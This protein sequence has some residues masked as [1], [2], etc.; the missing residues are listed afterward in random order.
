MGGMG[1][2]WSRAVRSSVV[3]L[4]VVAALGAGL[5]HGVRAGVSAAGASTAGVSGVTPRRAVTGDARTHDPSLAHT[6]SGW[7]V[8]STGDPAVAGGTVQI[9]FSPDGRNWAFTGTIGSSIPAWVS[10]AV[11]GVSNLWA[12]D[13]SFHNGRWYLYYAASTFGSNR[14]IIGLFT[15]PTLDPKDPRYAWTDQGEVTE[16]VTTDDFNAIDPNLFVDTTGAAW[17]AFGSFWSGV[18]LV[19]VSFP[20]GKPATVH[21]DRVSLVDRHFGPNAVEAPFLVAHG[22]WYY[23]FVSFD[24]CCQGANSTY[25]LV[26]G[27]SSTVTGPYLDRSGKSLLAGGATA[28]L[29]AQGDM[30]GPG[31]ASVSGDTV[32][33]H[34]YDAAKAGDFHLGL[35]HLGF[36]DGWPVITDLRI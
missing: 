2:G 19:P 7:Y 11:P 28:T 36:R 5:G 17:L 35:G 26:V 29:D 25:H 12:P 32:A 27:R 1:I 30:R 13:V 23:L 31:G 10:Q 16:S 20:S 4:S 15:N 3:A 6:A 14:S 22:G 34:Y 21:P 8:F 9:R 24:F 33:F 18:K